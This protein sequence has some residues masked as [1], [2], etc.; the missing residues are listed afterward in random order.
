MVR[1]GIARSAL[2]ALLVLGPALG[3][4]AQD[5][6]QTLRVGTKEAPPFAMKAPDGG[7]QGLSVDL[8]DAVADRLGAGIVWDERP[9]PALIDGV[10]AG[11][12]DA[13]IAAITVTGAREARVDF[14][15]RYFTTGLGVAVGRAAGADG[16]S[17]LMGFLAPATLALFGVLAGIAALVGGAVWLLERRRN[18]EQ[19]PP[20]PVRGFWNGV[21]W[22][23]VTMTT[24]GYGDKAPVTAA[25]RV[26]AVA[27]MLA[28]LVL[29]SLFTAHVTSLLTV[30]RLGSAVSSAQ[31]LPRVRVGAVRDAASI[32]TLEA[33]GVRPRLFADIPDGLAA[34]ARGDVDAFVHDAPLL[35]WAAGRS[36]EAVTITPILFDLQDYAIVLPE[37]SA[38][39]E[40]VNRAML[41]VMASDRWPAMRQRWLGEP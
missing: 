17:L 7:W 19:F 29:T 13:S 40:P 39:R 11:D 27:W 22:A 24:V 36:A 26:V 18:P 35:A 5:A 2:A 1:Q 6:R 20:A 41:E 10:A 12:L 25:G 23:A 30:D 14:S 9:L 37:G 28:A 21:W 16:W 38:L 34:V 33:L 15:H 4:A 8:M 32:G 31:D 3:A